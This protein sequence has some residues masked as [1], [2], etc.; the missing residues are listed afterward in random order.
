M[1][2][3]DLIIAISNREKVP[4]KI[5]YDGKEMVYDGN[6]QDYK[7]YYSNGNG[8]WLFQY[9]FDRCK[10]TSHFINDYVEVLEDKEIEHYD[11]F[12]NFTGFGFGGTDKELL[13][14][15]QNNFEHINEELDYLIKTVNKL[16]K[17]K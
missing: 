15:L 13:S 6:K 3:I 17:G 2:I 8:E 1:K 16:K 5:K 14:D 10:N 4:Y 7:G 12:D 9:L 11:M